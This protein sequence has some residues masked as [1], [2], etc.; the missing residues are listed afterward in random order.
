MFGKFKDELFDDLG[1][2]DIQDTFTEFGNDIRESFGFKP[3]MTN[4]ENNLRFLA[5]CFYFYDKNLLAV[6]A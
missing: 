1:I 5:G 6:S 4:E 3:K 2:Y